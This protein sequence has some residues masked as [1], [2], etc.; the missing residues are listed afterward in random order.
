MTSFAGATKAALRNLKVVFV[1]GTIQSDNSAM[2]ASFVFTCSHVPI[3][4]LCSTSCIFYPSFFHSFTADW[5]NKPCSI[6]GRKRLTEN[7]LAGAISVLE[8]SRWITGICN[9]PTG[10]ASH[11]HTERRFDLCPHATSSLTAIYCV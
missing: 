5:T 2:A 4:H 8:M 6:P 1:F 10:S 7:S 9:C 11:P 3:L